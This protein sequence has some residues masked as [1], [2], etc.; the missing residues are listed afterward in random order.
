MNAQLNDAAGTPS[1][2]R[3]QP[4]AVATRRRLLDSAIRL[5]A[6][7]GYSSTGV[8][9]IIADSGMTG[10][11]F[12]HHFETKNAVA[13]AILAEAGAKVQ[14]A[15][16][17]ADLGGPAVEAV[18]RGTFAVAS[19]HVRD[20]G[21]RVSSQLLHTVGISTGATARYYSTWVDALGAQFA[22][23]QSQ[24]DVRSDADPG[25]LGRSIVCAAYGAWAVAS[26]T[27]D[28]PRITRQLTDLW[29]M[30][31]PAILV[32]DRVPQFRDFLVEQGLR[33]QSSR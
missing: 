31:L 5:F 28:G 33:P 4:R 1:A 18:I 6:E 12:Y 26:L 3:P 29:D 25:V 7:Q 27:V 9:Q 11:A 32:A 2:K 21:V 8:K 13:S 23:A 17:S 14:S 24:G 15:F 22:R 10:G 16:V 19:L 20:A 30:M